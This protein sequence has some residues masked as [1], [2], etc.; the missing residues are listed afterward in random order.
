MVLCV[1]KRR[2]Y[3]EQPL[4]RSDFFGTFCQISE[5]AFAD[6]RQIVQRILAYTRRRFARFQCG[7]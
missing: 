6:V 1:T 2:K 4:L 3:L 7:L 5:R